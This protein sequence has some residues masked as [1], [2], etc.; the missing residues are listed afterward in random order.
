MVYVPV[1]V[2]FLTCLGSDNILVMLIP[3]QV[4]L[5]RILVQLPTMAVLKLGVLIPRVLEVRNVLDSPRRWLAF[6]HYLL[7]MP[8]WLKR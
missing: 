2:L 8:S 5:F 3:A 7:R 6:N 1:L 4:N